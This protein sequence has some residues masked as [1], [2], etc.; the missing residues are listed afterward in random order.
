MRPGR[1]ADLEPL[2]KLWAADVREGRRDSVPRE[3]YLRG[4]LANIDWEAR[5]RV[6]DDGDGLAAAVIVT[7]RSTS[8]GVVAYV[9][10][11][12]RPAVALELTGWALRLSRAAGARAAEVM[13]AQGQ[14]DGLRKLGMQMVRPWWRMDRSLV[15]ELP[16]PRLAEFQP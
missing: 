1:A 9:D 2:M 14:G 3:T 11:A 5:S 12:G 16:E 6:I 13:S 15:G 4:H 8:G 7:S 10:P